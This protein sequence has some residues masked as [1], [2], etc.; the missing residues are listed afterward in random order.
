M[1]RI[2]TESQT[3]EVT[4]THQDTKSPEILLNQIAAATHSIMAGMYEGVLVSP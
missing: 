3:C 4:N 1:R 2:D